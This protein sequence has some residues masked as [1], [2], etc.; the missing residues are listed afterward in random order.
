MT[1]AFILSYCAV[2]LVYLVVERQE[3]HRN[4]AVNKILLASM[5]LIY[6]AVAI[7]RAPFSWY[8]AWFLVALFFCYLGD[9]FLLW[10]FN[11]G[12]AMFII[13]NLLFFGYELTAALQ[14]GL[15]VSQFWW[16]LFFFLIPFCGITYFF[17]RPSMKKD[18]KVQMG[19]LMYMITITLHGSM[20][21]VLL[22]FFHGTPLGLLGLGS[23]LFEISDYCLMP[24]EKKYKP[25]KKWILNLNSLTYFVGML[26]MV[27]SLTA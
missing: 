23:F 2:L 26:L 1:T 24:Y 16:A 9:V 18:G 17:T 10:S 8:G 22:I 19:L 15:H 13:G 11:R 3:S 20:G 14:A 21:L 27:L 25:D 5:F 7:F 12:G 4:R 6:G